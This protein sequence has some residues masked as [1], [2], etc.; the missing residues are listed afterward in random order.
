M[1]PTTV[2]AAVFDGATDPTA[3]PIERSKDQWIGFEN[4]LDT[5]LA[6]CSADSDCAFHNDGD[7]EGAF[8]ALMAQLDDLAVA[9][10]RRPG[11][12]VA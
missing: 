10:R 8:D 3:D 1:F 6:Q 12:G 4:A 5:F 2:R 11:G 9:E 7:A